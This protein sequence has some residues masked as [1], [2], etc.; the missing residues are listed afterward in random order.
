MSNPNDGASAA[1]AILRARARALA[2][3]PHDG[4]VATESLELLEFRLAQESYALETRHVSEVVPLKDLTPVPCTPPFILGVVN[5]R[6]RITPVIDLKKFFDLPEQGLS[7]MHRVILVRNDDLEFGLLADAISGV[8]PL[9]LD[10]LQ[11]S[12]P[13]L[14][15]IRIDYL[16]GVTADRV[17]VLDLDRI[18]ADPRIIVHEE[19]EN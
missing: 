11:A 6:G 9:A 1:K 14:T 8:R 19:V 16:K 17:V 5:V 12:L 13:T 18:L 7:D 4:A 3:P 10:S 15:G 2:R